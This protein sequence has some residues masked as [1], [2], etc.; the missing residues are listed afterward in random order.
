M[1]LL[2]YLSGLGIFNLL[3]LIVMALLIY[4]AL[5]WFK[6]T[7]AAFVL[8]GMALI[9]GVYVVARF[10]GL[11]L[12][13]AV[14]QGFFAVI[15]IAVIVIFQEEIKQFFEQIA[16]RSIIKNIGRK[17]P[18]PVF[19][20]ESEVIVRTLTDLAKENIGALVV[21]R[22]K[23]PVVR[24]LDGGIE[25][26]GELS[27]SIL[28]SIF[29]PHSYGH[30]GAVIIESNRITQFSSH[31]PLS[32]NF[33]KL[34]YMG[35]RHAAALGL[36]EVTD[37]LCLVVS[38]ER[39]RIS[40]ARFGDIRHVDNPDELTSIL[41]G[42]Y[43]EVEP[44]YHPRPWT[45][46]F[47]KNYRE[48]MIAIAVTMVLWFVLVYGGKT[49]YKNINVPVEYA[50]LPAELKVL[51]VEPK[52]VELTISGPRRAFYFFNENRVKINLSLFTSRPGSFKKTVSG[53]DIQ[54]PTGI[55]LDRIEPSAIEFEIESQIAQP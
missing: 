16:S 52:V 54:L 49:E 24:H 40:V 41:D 17:K 21:L 19:H 45:D 31:L 1:N 29:D 34:A 9:A 43:R 13:T 55:V 28:K 53:S 39:G 33:E 27:E 46:F 18:S 42:F 7:Q 8:F 14:F 10:F 36:S 2:N 4:S 44:A 50:N 12:T 51:Q 37:A 23:S 6:R 26:H 25:L 38:E 15:L 48:K 22:G 32:K 3:D 30:D 20:R 35:T 5:V 47:K 11:Y